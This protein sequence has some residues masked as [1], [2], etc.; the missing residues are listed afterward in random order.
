M[1]LVVLGSGSSVPHAKRTSSA[2]WIESETSKILIDCA[3]SAICRMPQENLKWFEIDSI[4]ISHFHLDHVGGLAPLLFSLKY[5]PETQ[6]RKK[7]LRIFGPY[8][9]TRLI[10]NFDSVNNYRLFEQVFSLEI[11]EIESL[12]EFQIAD[13]LVAVALK[14]PHTE[15]SLAISIRDRIGRRVVFTSDTG[16]DIKLADFARRA[17]LF[18][19]ECSFVESKPV[20]THLQ[21]SEAIHLVRRAEPKQAMLTHFYPEW[22]AVVFQEQVERLSPGCEV[23][24]AKDGLILQVL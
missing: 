4:W 23:V 11:H 2:Y 7:P 14:T 3:P 12:Q 19:L 9:L 18:I 20:Q 10:K 1:R 6:S 17:E 8:G 5:S 15:E 21:L 24:E 22:D 13:D 16:Y